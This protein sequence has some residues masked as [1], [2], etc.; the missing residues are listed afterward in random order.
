MKNRIII[1]VEDKVPSKLLVPLSI[2]YMSARFGV[3]C[4]GAVRVWNQPCS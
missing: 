2:R 3:C 4:A 1:Q